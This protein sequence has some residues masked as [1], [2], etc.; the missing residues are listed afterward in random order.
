MMKKR[1]PKSRK[2][3]HSAKAGRKPQSLRIE[4]SWKDAVKSALKRGKPPKNVK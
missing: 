1:K 2:D 4:G 3:L